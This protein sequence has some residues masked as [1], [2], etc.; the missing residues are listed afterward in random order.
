MTSRFDNWPLD[1]LLTE[2]ARFGHVEVKRVQYVGRPRSSDRWEAEI[3]LP[4]HH[5]PNIQ[6]YFHT[7]ADDP[8]GAMLAAVTRAHEWAASPQRAI[9]RQRYLDDVALARE[10]AKRERGVF[11]ERYHAELP[12]IDLSDDGPNRV[13]PVE[14]T[15]HGG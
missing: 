1:E 15:D 12:D 9:D 3:R 8:R 7:H 5:G 6:V 13:Q 2:A 11:H 10:T 14:E 4:T